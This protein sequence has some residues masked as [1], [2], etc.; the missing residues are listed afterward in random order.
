MGWKVTATTIK[1]E[2][3]DEFTVLLVYGDGKSRCTYF[4]KHTNSKDK[5]N[6]LANCQGMN[7]PK[8][9]EFKERA[10]EI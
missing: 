5:E 6:R 3:V 7:C 4:E 2:K 10:F 8:L 1:C 9:A